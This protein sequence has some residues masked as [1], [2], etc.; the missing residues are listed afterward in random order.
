[1]SVNH[2]EVL[3]KPVSREVWLNVYVSRDDLDRLGFSDW[4]ALQSAN[5]SA[6]FEIVPRGPRAFA[7]FQQRNPVTY[8]SDPGEA[9]IEAIS[10]VRNDIWE[11]VKLA[12]PYRKHYVYCCAS[13]DRRSRLP[14]LLSVYL[15]MFFL[16]SVTRY[17]PGYFEDLLESRY[18]P[19]FD[20]FISE[21]PLQFLY[22]MA[23]EIVG[24]E[25][26][27]PAII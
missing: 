18:G 1:M 6:G 17:N 14:Q 25:V 8:R 5:L 27:K 26:S 15:L 20:T 3:H 19:F 7:C 22:I 11:T 12:S 16:G 2:F 23:S 13:S 9:L 4:A 21:S 10:N 24:R